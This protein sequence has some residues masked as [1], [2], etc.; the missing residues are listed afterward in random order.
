MNAQAACLGRFLLQRMLR[1]STEER[2]F[3]DFFHAPGAKEDRCM[4]AFDLTL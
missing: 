1:P 2:F 3:M 4:S